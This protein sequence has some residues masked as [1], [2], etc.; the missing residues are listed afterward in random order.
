MQKEYEFYSLGMGGKSIIKIDG[1]TL[2]ISR[3]GLMSKMSLGFT[4]DKTVMIN[5]ISGVQ[6]KKVG[7]ARGY[8]QFIMAGTKEAK[9]GIIGGK[10]DEN[11]V[12][13]D[14]FFKN[15]NNQINSNFEEIKKYIEEF[16]SNQNRNTTIIQNVKS[17][18][19]QVK[20]LKEL[21]DMGAISQE[22]FD[23]KKKELL[24]L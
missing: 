19:E 20:E 15:K 3:P 21:L 17:P 9:S 24:N 16:N 6:I 8:I 1:N 14:S 10:I 23:K 7:L 2:T 22:E 13:S 12:Y 4:G 11:I 5:Q 18:A